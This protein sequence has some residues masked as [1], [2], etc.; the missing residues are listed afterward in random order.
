MKVETACR[1]EPETRRN[2]QIQQRNSTRTRTE[3]CFEGTAGLPSFRRFQSRGS[4]CRMLSLCSLSITSAPARVQKVA[5]SFGSRRAFL[6]RVSP[7]FV[8]IDQIQFSVVFCFSPA[9]SSR[10]GQRTP[11]ALGFPSARQHLPPPCAP[12][13][14]ATSR[15]VPVVDVCFCLF[16]V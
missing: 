5:I 15:L 13:L 4:L 1:A 9:V 2:D 11:S 8:P 10:L 6:Q 16:S 3:C 14:T 7:S 12:A